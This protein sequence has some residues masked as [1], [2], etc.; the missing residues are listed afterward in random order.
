M[1]SLWCDYR[2]TMQR[3]SLLDH[4]AQCIILINTSIAL[5]IVMPLNISRLQKLIDEGRFRKAD[6][7]AS[8]GI[9]KGTLENVL[10]GLDPKVSTLQAIATA[11]GVSIT[12]FFDEGGEIEVRNA[13]RDYVERGKIE[14]RGTEYNGSGTVESDLR[15]QIA[16]LKSQLED[17]ERIIKLMEDRKCGI[18][19]SR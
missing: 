11:I 2:I 4:I 12:Y 9:S 1:L 15:E 18:K 7:I 17:K 8:S 14:H 10:K 5:K 13:G 6:I 19:Y 3:Y 16:Q